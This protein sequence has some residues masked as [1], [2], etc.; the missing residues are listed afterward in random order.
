MPGLNRWFISEDKPLDTRLWGDENEADQYQD[1]LVTIWDQLSEELKD[2]SGDAVIYELFNE[3]EPKTESLICE[4]RGILWENLQDRIINTIRENGD[5]HLVVASPAYSWQTESLAGWVPS[6][7]ILNDENLIVSVHGY[8]PIKFTIQEEA[9]YGNVDYN[10]Y[11]GTYNEE[12][13]GETTW[14]YDAIDNL[15][16]NTV[17][18]FYDKYGIQVYIA[19]FAVNREAPGAELWLLD[20]MNLMN[21]EYSDEIW[22]WS[23]HVWEEDQYARLNHLDYSWGR[24]GM[25]DFSADP[26]QLEAVLAGINNIEE[27]LME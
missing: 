10:A 1:L 18:D 21:K 25:N 22:G 24:A 4:D 16:A 15:F 11:P 14:N 6:E 12:H 9:W 27:T 13:Y 3:A 23:V 8:R 26:E 17:G 19:E 5:S 2:E 7:T 20:M